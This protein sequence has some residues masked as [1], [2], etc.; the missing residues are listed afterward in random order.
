MAVDE[1]LI[2]LVPVFVRRYWRHSFAWGLELVGAFI[3]SIL[4]L[5][6]EASQVFIVLLT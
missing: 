3:L 2:I 5:D 6:S 4:W 1:G